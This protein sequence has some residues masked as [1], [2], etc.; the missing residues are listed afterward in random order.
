MSDISVGQNY[1]QQPSLFTAV[2]ETQRVANQILRSN[3]LANAVTTYGLM[4]W[5]GRYGSY[6]LWIGE[7]S[8]N[9][10]NKLDPQGNT[11]PQMGFVLRR[12]DAKQNY[13]IELYDY[14]PYVGGPLRQKLQFRDADGRPLM[15][16]GESGGWGWPRFP[17]PM[18]QTNP[19]QTNTASAVTLF[20]RSQVVGRHIDFM[21]A[22]N[23]VPMWTF[24]G[25]AGFGNAAVPLWTAGPNAG[26]QLTWNLQVL[27]GANTVT[28]PNAT[29]TGGFV[30]STLDLGT[31]WM[32]TTAADYMILNFNSWITGG[33]NNAYQVNP[34]F[35]H[36]VTLWTNRQA[37]GF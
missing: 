18:Y 22:V 2:A 3:P 13:A 1:P 6:Y 19:A 24:T 29:T 26:F 21:F 4:Q 33:S 27:I 36:N 8:P 5:L 16:E 32:P 31:S 17:V 37:E 25:A 34:V 15:G 35:F 12:D 30:Q 28:T 7:F 11:L 20:G 14:D 9:D 23:A 10:P